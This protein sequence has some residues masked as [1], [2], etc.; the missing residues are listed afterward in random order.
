MREFLRS[1]GSK[2]TV[3]SRNE[4]AKVQWLERLSSKLRT[5]DD[6]WPI[7]WI[8]QMTDNDPEKRPVSNKLWIMTRGSSP[9]P[10][11]CCDRCRLDFASMS[12]PRFEFGSYQA[13]LSYKSSL[14]QTSTLAATDTPT[15]KGVP[16]RF[17]PLFSQI[18][19]PQP[20]PP[21]TQPLAG[22]QSS[23]RVA[24]MMGMGTVKGDFTPT[25]GPQSFSQ[26]SSPYYPGMYAQSSQNLSPLHPGQY[27]SRSIPY[28][29]SP[30]QSLQHQTALP[31]HSGQ[32]VSRSSPY[33]PSPLQSLQHQT[34]LPPHSGQY[35]YRSSPYYDSYLQYLLHR[36]PSP[37]PPSPITTLQG[38]EYR[39]SARLTAPVPI[40]SEDQLYIAGSNTG[41]AMMQRPPNTLIPESRPALKSTV[42]K[43]ESTSAV[44]GFQREPRKSA[45]VTIRAPDGRK[46][47]LASMEPN[48]GKL[49]DLT[50]TRDAMTSGVSKADISTDKE[51]SSIPA[52]DS[53]P[54][55]WEARIENLL[56][57]R[58]PT[59][60]KLI[61]ND[62]STRIED[63]R[64]FSSTLKLSPV[65]N[66]VTTSDH[67]AKTKVEAQSKPLPYTDKRQGKKTSDVPPRVENRKSTT[68]TSLTTSYLLPSDSQ[69]TPRK[70]VWPLIPGLIK[71]AILFHIKQPT[72]IKADRCTS[73]RYHMPATCRNRRASI[74][75]DEQ[76][77]DFRGCS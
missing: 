53:S 61:S 37:Y 52:Q 71:V 39:L 15:L 21:Q 31:P 62:R 38:G 49:N 48:I 9:I 28:Y 70:D 14:A 73:F 20:F 10:R 2:T 67:L 44:P 3:V 50:D 8:Q 5:S 19:A 75:S 59:T 16:D 18:A 63:L 69:P 66:N 40:S 24:P 17:Q 76:L 23:S 42:Q 74:F 57:K 1:T 4:S 36:T 6:I 41:S 11:Y 26:Q 22:P 56:G 7:S 68:T 12:A 47:N 55:S 32:Y 43:A 13:A 45:A 25:N 54:T 27:V 34:A 51:G 72:L 46:L 30:L 60:S 64:R 65:G 33:Y 58:M 35:D 29:P 77:H